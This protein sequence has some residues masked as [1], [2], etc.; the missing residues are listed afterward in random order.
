MLLLSFKEQVISSLSYTMVFKTAFITMSMASYALAASIYMPRSGVQF[1]E[2]STARVALENARM[3]A[4]VV[5]HPVGLNIR[6]TSNATL[7]VSSY[8]VRQSGA[9]NTEDYELYLSKFTLTL[10][11]RHIIVTQNT[12]YSEPR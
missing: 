5:G 1:N 11:M 2:D 12:T 3:T 8:N 4:P 10:C 9:L 7:S 6:S